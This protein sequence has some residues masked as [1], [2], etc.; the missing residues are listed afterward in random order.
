MCAL[1]TSFNNAHNTL[2]PPPHPSPSPYNPPWS[3]IHLA[4]T[5]LQE[6]RRLLDAERQAQLVDKQQRKEALQ[7]GT[8]VCVPVLLACGY[9]F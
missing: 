8:V 7:V 5:C 2:E 1:C 9:G 6:R 3:P 4:R